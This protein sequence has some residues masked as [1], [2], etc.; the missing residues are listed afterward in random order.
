MFVLPDKNGT[1]HKPK[2]YLPHLAA[3]VVEVHQGVN[4]YA[5]EL[6]R[7]LTP[8]AQENA[9]GL[10][11]GTRHVFASFGLLLEQAA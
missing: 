11:P 1:P 5:E 2:R 3:E 7:H 4:E 9:L 10:N 8:W 6:V